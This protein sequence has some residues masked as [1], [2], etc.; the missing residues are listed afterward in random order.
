MLRITHWLDNRLIDGGKVVIPT[1]T[2]LD[3]SHRPVF[4][5]KLLLVCSYLTGN[6]I[7]SPLSAQQLN[8]IY[9]FVTMVS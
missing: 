1:I 9:R 2:I 7:R 3:I 4:Y 8:A 6:I 5:L